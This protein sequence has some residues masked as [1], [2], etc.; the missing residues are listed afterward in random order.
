MI[1]TSMRTHHTCK[2]FF[3]NKPLIRGESK[4]LKKIKK[5]KKKEYFIK[6]NNRKTYDSFMSNLKGE[7]I[8]SA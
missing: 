7:T 2:F 5:K 8:I 6:I 4:S 3:F 1:K